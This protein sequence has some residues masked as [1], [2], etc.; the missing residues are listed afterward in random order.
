MR[1]EGNL[2]LVFVSKRRP[3][4]GLFVRFVHQECAGLLDDVLRVDNSGNVLDLS[5]FRN[6]VR[7]APRRPVVECAGCPFWALELDRRLILSMRE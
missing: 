7:N 2:V 6:L 4:K 1:E 3:Q 5:D